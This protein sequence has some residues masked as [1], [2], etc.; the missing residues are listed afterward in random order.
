MFI[1]ALEAFFDYAVQKISSV[2]AGVATMYFNRNFQKVMGISPQKWR[3]NDNHFVRK[4]LNYEVK[5]EKGW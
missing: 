1:N 4:L 5:V 3:K 2:M